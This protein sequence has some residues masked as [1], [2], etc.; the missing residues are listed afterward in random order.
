MRS[1]RAKCWRVTRAGGGG[2]KEE[3]G[4]DE[5]QNVG[6]FPGIKTWQT[7]KKATRFK[8]LKTLCEKGGE[9]LFLLGKTG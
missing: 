1:P 9:H 5:E 4:S 3:K 6:P 7:K 2:L 8:I